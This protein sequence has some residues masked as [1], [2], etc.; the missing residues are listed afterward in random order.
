LLVQL[1]VGDDLLEVQSVSH[2]V[3]KKGKEK[4]APVRAERD[5]ASL[6]HS[7]NTFAKPVTIRHGF[8]YVAT[9]EPRDVQERVEP[10]LVVP[11]GWVLMK[12]YVIPEV[13]NVVHEESQIASALIREEIPVRKLKA[14]EKCVDV[15]VPISGREGLQQH[16]ITP[17]RT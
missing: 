12:R 1:N 4:V 9:D 14:E 17:V 3:E 10:C 16:S 15:V 8:A 13:I 7:V 6:L 11:S 2:L 5:P